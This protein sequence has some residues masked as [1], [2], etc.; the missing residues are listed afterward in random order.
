[1]E[2]YFDIGAFGGVI[3]AA[4]VLS[5]LQERIKGLAQVQY[6]SLPDKAKQWMWLPSFIIGGVGVF[7][8]GVDAMPLFNGVWPWLGRALT[9]CAGALG[10]SAVFDLFDALTK[11]PKLDSKTFEAQ[12]AKSVCDGLCEKPP[13][14]AR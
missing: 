6:D 13:G 14:A 1:M 10:P 7:A 11:R 2:P 8:T 4:I 9:C 12:V 3:A 5:F